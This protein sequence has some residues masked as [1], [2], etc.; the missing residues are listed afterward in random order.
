M[1]I[2]LIAPLEN[3]GVTYPIGTTGTLIIENNNALLSTKELDIIV[4]DQ[5][6]KFKEI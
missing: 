3:K 2:K 1:K 6:I 5:V 4:I